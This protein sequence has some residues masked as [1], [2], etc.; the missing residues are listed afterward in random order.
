MSLAVVTVSGGNNAYPSAMSAFALPWYFGT[1]SLVAKGFKPPAVSTPATAGTGTLIEGGDGTLVNEIGLS[2]KG[3]NRFVGNSYEWGLD[4]TTWARGAGAIATNYD[5]QADGTFAQSHGAHCRALAAGAYSAGES[6]ITRAANAVGV[7]W[8]IDNAAYGAAAIGMYLVITPEADG[9]FLC[10]VNAVARVPGEFVHGS[11]H[12]AK[13][14]FANLDRREV[15]LYIR[16]QAAPAN[17]KL[18]ATNANPTAQEFTL[19][20]YCLTSVRARVSAGTTAFGKV[21]CEEAVFLV[22]TTSGSIS[23]IVG[24]IGWTTFGQTFASQ[25]WS[26]TISVT[27]KT[28]RFACNPGTDDVEFFVRIDMMDQAL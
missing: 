6:V 12:S 28:L 3:A 7:G 15:G 21:A 5:S 16:A 1:Q 24:A 20:E 18:R 25:G 27:G 23:T 4:A 10:G 2:T 8:T 11:G 13:I 9:A 17:A 22:K 14:G 19:Q 26:V